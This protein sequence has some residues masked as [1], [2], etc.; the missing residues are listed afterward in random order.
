MSQFNLSFSPLLPWPVLLGLGVLAL[1]LVGLG[2]YARGGGSFLRALALGLLLLA[3]TGPALEREDRNPLKEVVAVVVDQSGSQT[4]GERPAQTE[5]ARAGLEKSLNA[6]GNVE[7]RVIESGRTD[8]ETDG[9]RLFTALNAGLADVPLER[10]GG[11][12]M[13][14]DGVVDDIPVDAGALGFKA[15][16]HALITGHEGERDRRIELLEAPRFGIVGKDQ[17]IELR[18]SDT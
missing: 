18:V 9:T 6:L 10:L 5:N 1:G 17:T 14:T 2:F 12:F 3:M 4:I 13:I 11:V 7:V 15:P 16:L 8:S